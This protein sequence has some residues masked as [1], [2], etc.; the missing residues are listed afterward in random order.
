MDRV[1]IQALNS[2]RGFGKALLVLAILFFLTIAM[3]NAA[4][5]GDYS[6]TN[7]LGPAILARWDAGI[8]KLI[9][10]HCKP[11]TLTTSDPILT[12]GGEFREYWPLISLSGPIPLGFTLIYG[13]DLQFKAPVNDGRQQ[14]P[15]WG[16]LKAFNSSTFIRIVEAEVRTVTPS[17]VYINVMIADDTLVFKDD[18]TGNFLPV[19]PVKYQIE[20]VSTYYY[21]MDPET[22]KVYIFRSRYLG[23][24][25]TAQFF[26]RAGEAVYVMDRNGNMLSYTYNEDNLPTAVDDGL[27][28]RLN[29][30]YVN[31]TQK[32]ERNLLQV[33]DGFGR[34]VDFNYQEW[35]CNGEQTGVLV[36]F[37]DPMGQT[38]TFDYYDQTNTDCNL[39]RKINRPLG[40]SPIDQTWVQNP[41]G[42]SAVDSQKDAY[43][44]ET[45]LSFSQDADENVI[46]TVD[47]PDGTQRIFHHERERYPLDSTDPSGKQFT[48]DYN[49][50]DQMTA[51]NDR[52]GATTGF[53][54]HA[55]SGKVATITN[56]K[57][58]TTTFTYTAQ[59]QTF[60]N[61]LTSDTVTFTFYLLT[62]IDHPDGTQ[63]QFTY[64]GK[65]NM[66]TRIDR[67]GKTWTYT[68]NPMGQ[69]LTVTNPLSGVITHTYN[70]DGTLATR[71][72][73]D[74]GTTTYAYDGYKRV[75]RITRPDA[76]FV[77]M[78]YNLNDQITAITDEN[79]HT[80]TYTR[81]ANGNVIRVTDP[82]GN[83]TQY[84][85]DLMD[86]VNR[87]TDRLGK[88]ATLTY[89]SMGRAATITDPTAIQTAFGYDP[90]GWRNSTALGSRTWQAGYDDEGVVASR[91]TPLGHTTAYQ[92]DNLGYTTGISNPL[93]QVTTFARDAMSR[94]T[95]VTD[96]LSRTAS[97]G[98]DNRGLLSSV[99]LPVVGTA[100]YT[101]NDLG[102]L[103]GITDPGGSNWTFGHTPMGRLQSHVDP[104][105]N[106]WQ[107]TY[108]ARGRLNQTTF[109]DTGTLTRAYDSAGNPIG[110]LYSDGTD[111][112][113]TYDDLNRLS[114]AN[115][116]SLTRDAE[117]R[118][119][120]T[121]NPGTV[122]GAT[123]DGAGRLATVTYN[124]GAFAVTYTYDATT[125]LPS[126]VT[127]S[128]TGTQVVFTYDN[129]GRQT[130]ITRSNGVNA[131]FTWNDADRLT[132]IQDGDIV[133]ILYSYDTAGQVTGA[134]M[135]V[136]LDPSTCLTDNTET[137]T[138]DAASQ[139][140]TAGYDYDSRGRRIASPGHTYAWDGASRNTG[141]DGATQTYNG[142]GDLVT[143]TEGGTTSHNYYNYALGLPQMVA[144][145]NDTTGHFLRYYVWTPDGKLLYMIDA[146]DGNKVYYFHFDR[147]GSTLALTDGTGTVTDAYAYTPNGEQL[148]QIG[149][150]EQP[151][152]FMGQSGVCKV[153][154]DGTLY[155]MGRRIYDAARGG[156]FLDRTPY[157]GI[158]DMDIKWTNPY[159]CAASNLG[160]QSADL[161]ERNSENRDGIVN[162]GF[163]RK[164]QG[165]SARNLVEAYWSLNFGVN[166]SSKFILK[167]PSKYPNSRYSR[168]LPG[169]PDSGA[170][171]GTSQRAP[172]EPERLN[173]GQPILKDQIWF[174][175]L[176]EKR[177]ITGRRK[178]VVKPLF[179]NW[180]SPQ[181][182]GWRTPAD[183][184]V[185]TGWRLSKD[186]PE[187]LDP[188]VV[189]LGARIEFD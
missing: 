9:K 152:T 172:N 41:V 70:A 184:L 27:G 68:Y 26:R 117:G 31:S 67:A 100:T 93:S 89:D 96:P 63:E 25:W 54:H 7:P 33:A 55:P 20:K 133:D 155:R 188:R 3:T 76:T 13:P 1:D 174:F 34:T 164:D 91:T 85:Y 115:R 84:A 119:T 161:F 108:D 66:L 187:L 137:Y 180:D 181:N 104:L 131:T 140:S 175:G 92:T 73:S 75:N 179:E 88:A 135:T 17:D 48:I 5:A 71:T 32:S 61:P 141:Y 157:R 150:S 46:T 178:S 49:D 56:A 128:L 58:D 122:F 10:Q 22:E 105:G 2:K 47:Y 123:R 153:G 186:L 138:Y 124:N 134:N 83:R 23:W 136:P 182:Y 39:V 44:N 101:R 129:D 189:R 143:R 139:V 6:I 16:Q 38:T 40:N 94:V 60:T 80:Y 45:T 148:G 51:I 95:A 118:V 114:T 78:T 183:P 169:S 74:T 132:R 170:V 52:M 151:H 106:T 156:I 59:T 154:K 29:L 107:H 177:S 158:S 79:N 50:Q 185:E 113:Y 4:L 57:G 86:R 121:D 125:G 99:T 127:D 147:T 24:D 87:I 168:R 176:W 166:P 173:L 69:I 163:P 12:G 65:G 18:G 8:R 14:F 19:G 28:R 35:T 159:Q 144:E 112:Q 82:A 109:P 21:M 165:T 145:K 37:T 97:Y 162:K 120:A 30:T 167:Y 36:S 81:D 111:L 110:D 171:Y 142:L 160:A 146:S 103:S 62:R 98:Y 53:T 130:G 90:R 64:D 43:N 42:V 72:D 77:Q 149:S 126:G 15:P 11:H 102:L 116:I